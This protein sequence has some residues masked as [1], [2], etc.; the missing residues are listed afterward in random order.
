MTNIKTREDALKIVKAFAH[1][2]NSG[3]A[4]AK[5]DWDMVMN[6]MHEFNISLDDVNDAK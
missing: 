6:L 5:E 2:V 4:G 1:F 3:N